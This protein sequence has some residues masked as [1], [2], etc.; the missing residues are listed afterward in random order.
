MWFKNFPT[1]CM[2]C[3]RCVEPRFAQ[4]LQYRFCANFNKTCK[5]TLDQKDA[6]QVVLG[7]FVKSSP[8][9]TKIS[10]LF[11]DEIGT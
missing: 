3:C 11:K 2:Y 8:V 1:L 6:Q 10:T 4:K 9:S 5:P 7:N